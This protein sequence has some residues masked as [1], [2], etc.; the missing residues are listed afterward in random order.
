[1]KLKADLYKQNKALVLS[2]SENTILDEKVCSNLLYCKILHI[3]YLLHIF[4][5][6]IHYII[7]SILLV[8]AG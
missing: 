1:M 7:L 6:Y 3:F 2:N 8:D 5:V 4:H